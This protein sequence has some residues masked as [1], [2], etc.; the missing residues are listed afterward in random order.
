MATIKYIGSKEQGH[1]TFTKLTGIVWFPGETNE[2]KEEHA[3]VLLRH[4]DAFELVP[5]KKTASTNKP[6]SAG[7]AA[8]LTPGVQVGEATATAPAKPAR[9][10]AAKKNAP[11]KRAPR[12]AAKTKD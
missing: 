11:A 10:A 4:P 8:T 2:V 5:E 3:K 9:K 7:A 12:K 1:T 6:E